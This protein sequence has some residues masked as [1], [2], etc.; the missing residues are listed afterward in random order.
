MGLV[1]TLAYQKLPVVLKEGLEFPGVVGVAWLL[2][3]CCL[4]LIFFK[5]IYIGQNYL[6]CFPSHKIHRFGDTVIRIK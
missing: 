3:H 5:F 2:R 1:G 6:F 4:N